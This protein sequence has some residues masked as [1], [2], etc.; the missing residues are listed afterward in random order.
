MDTF[1]IFGNYFVFFLLNIIV[2]ED[3]VLKYTDKYYAL[4]RRGGL[5]NADKADK[6]GEGVGEMLTMCDKGRRGGLDPAIF[7]DIIC[8]QPLIPT[9]F[10]LNRPTGRICSSSRDVRPSHAIIVAWTGAES[11]L[12][13]DWCGAFIALAWSPLNGE[14]FGIGAPLPDLEKTIF[15]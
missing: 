14:G 13:V 12:S 1:I 3:N 7:A 4:K 2:H 11:P 8:E 5:E 6:G 15:L 10:S 9:F